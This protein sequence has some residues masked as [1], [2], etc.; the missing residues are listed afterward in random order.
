M[1]IPEISQTC[2]VLELVLSKHTLL[3]LL[4]F[5][6]DFCS[7]LTVPTIQRNMNLATFSDVIKIEV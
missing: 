6:V 4:Y 5:F 1:R 7:F 2:K 3:F